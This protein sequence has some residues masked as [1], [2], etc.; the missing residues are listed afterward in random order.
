MYNI[1]SLK[2]Q[3]LP[4]GLSNYCNDSFNLVN[5]TNPIKL[6]TMLNNSLKSNFGRKKSKKIFKRKKSKNK[7]RSFGM[8]PFQQG[9][10]STS[11]QSLGL[12]SGAKTP[13]TIYDTLPDVFNKQPLARPYGPVDNLRMQLPFK[14]TAFGS[15]KNR[16]KSKH[17]CKCKCCRKKSLSKSERKKRKSH[18]FGNMTPGTNMWQ[19]DASIKNTFS[20]NLNKYANADKLSAAK[21]YVSPSNLYMNNIS[22]NIPNIIGNTNLPGQYTNNQLNY[23]FLSNFGK[24]NKRKSKKISK[25]SLINKSKKIVRR[26]SLTIKNSKSSRS[27]GPL[28]SNVAGPNTIGYQES[29][30]LYKAGANTINFATNKLF[31]SNII[32]PDGKVQ[33]DGITPN[34]WLTQSVG[35]GDGLGNN[36]RFGKILEGK[37][38]TLNNSGQIDI[39]PA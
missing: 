23:P 19:K 28:I 34:A 38:I 32:K 3:P 36:Y 11:D 35:I 30:P 2:N 5:Y 26:P 8:Y 12:P 16:R 15:K 33:L 29:I 4:E 13:N 14:I 24:K 27:F 25:P 39:K 22:S 17:K 31:G 1:S 20:N 37:T 6:K 9:K 7:S 18:K 10:L 21:A